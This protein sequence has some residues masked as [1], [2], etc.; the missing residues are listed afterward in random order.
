MANQGDPSTGFAIFGLFL[1]GIGGGAFEAILFYKFGW[2]VAAL[3]LA[4]FLCVVGYQIAWPPANG[5]AGTS[6]N[7]AGVPFVVRIDPDDPD[8]GLPRRKA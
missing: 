6:G 8:A 2:Q 1:F 7:G 5:N 3:P 4:A